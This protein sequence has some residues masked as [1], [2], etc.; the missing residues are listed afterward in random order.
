[1]GRCGEDG[2][3]GGG[4][5]LMGSEDVGFGS[6]VD[7]AKRGEGSPSALKRYFSI[8]HPTKNINIGKKDVFK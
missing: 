2:G 5:G 3:G 6:I 8:R 4:G 1:M 7:D